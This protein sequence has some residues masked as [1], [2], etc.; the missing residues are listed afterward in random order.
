MNREEK[1][2]LFKRLG[3]IRRGERWIE[4]KKGFKQ[5]FFKSISQAYQQGKPTQGEHKMIDFLGK[6]PR[7]QP[8]KCWG[9]EGDH[10]YKDFPDKGDGMRTMHNIQE[11]NTLVHMGKNMPLIYASLDNRQENYQSHM[12]EVESKIDN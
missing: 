8:I 3:M 7:Q 10:V 2:Q 11:A 4:G 9:C 5:P 12:I 6:R 1:D